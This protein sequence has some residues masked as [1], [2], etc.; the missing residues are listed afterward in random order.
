MSGVFD[1]YGLTVTPA[2]VLTIR[3]VIMT[4]AEE[5]EFARDEFMRKWPDG[6]PVLG[7]DPVSPYAA[8][9]FTECT[10]V[11][12]DQCK[13][14]I[15]ELRELGGHLADAARD[16][17]RTEDEIKASFRNGMRH[18]ASPLVHPAA[19]PSG[20]LGSLPDPLN[21]IRSTW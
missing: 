3:K 15:D 18:A 8:Q 21:R 12:L 5:L 20:I 4:E 2:N 11:Y 14:R 16:Y 9:G 6:M 7:G 13:A 19:P 1:S 10:N 17:G